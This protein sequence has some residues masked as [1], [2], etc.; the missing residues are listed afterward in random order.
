MGSVMSKV[1]FAKAYE[2]EGLQKD[3]LKE[4]RQVE[5]TLNLTPK[6][7][8]RSGKFVDNPTN[9]AVNNNIELVVRKISSMVSQG[10]EYANG[11]YYIYVQFGGKPSITKSPNGMI[12]A[13][14]VLARKAGYIASINTGCIF[15]GYEVLRVKRNGI[16]DE[17]ELINGTE[18]EIGESVSKDSVGYAADILAP[19]A[20]VTLISEKTCNV[21]SRKVTIVRH[22]EYLAARAKGSSTHKVYPVPMA[23]KIALRRAAAEMSAALGVDDSDEAEE[24]KRE[25]TDHDNDYDIGGNA[26]P[27]DVVEQ[28]DPLKVDIKKL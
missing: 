11:D 27:V 6:T 19:Y 4:L 8:D 3:L 21:I 16:I 18:A 12:K 22:N 10:L 24:L 26:A 13:M 25:I 15:K 5:M 28:K 2:S 14:N 1:S 7:K 23:V 20:V 9:V 17:L